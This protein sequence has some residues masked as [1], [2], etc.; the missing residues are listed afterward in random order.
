V[1]QFADMD[2]NEFKSKILMQK[3]VQ[4]S[5]A[6]KLLGLSY[7]QAVV[8]YWTTTGAVSAVKNQGSCGSCWSF[9]TTGSLESAYQI[10]KGSLPNYSEQQLVDCCIAKNGYKC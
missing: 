9:S 1:T 4:P 5:T 10:A 2:K 7:K 3:P 8:V 6:P